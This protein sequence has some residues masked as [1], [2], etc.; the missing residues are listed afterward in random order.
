MQGHKFR[1]GQVVRL[2][3]GPLLHQA[4]GGD[5]AVTR[6]LPSSEGEL[7]Y[8]IK[9]VAESHERAVR[10]SQIALASRS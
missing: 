6:L 3:S 5:Y 9:S 4:T 1:I 2:V 10:E 8:R 7:N